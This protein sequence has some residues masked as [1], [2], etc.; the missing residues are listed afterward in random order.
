MD[1]N[2]VKSLKLVSTGEEEQID[3]WLENIR[4]KN[5]S[6]NQQLNEGEK[7]LNSASY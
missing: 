6:M 2:I 7:F 3:I 1:R 4:W 5:D